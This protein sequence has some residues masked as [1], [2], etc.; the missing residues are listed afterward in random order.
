[1]RAT[2][3]MTRVKLVR[4]WL[5]ATVLL[6]ALAGCATHPKVDPSINWNS[7]IGSYTYEQAVG[8]LGKPDFLAQ[9]N[10]GIAADWVLQQSP[11]MSFGFGVGGAGVG[12]GTSVS[13]AP[14]GKYLH[15]NFGPDGKL[16]SWSKIE[17]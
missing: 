12:A 11:Q 3:L 8:E 2:E 9:S 14:H 16:N 15:L 10:E 7:R 6:L 1:M 13:P 5:T 17:R 4:Q